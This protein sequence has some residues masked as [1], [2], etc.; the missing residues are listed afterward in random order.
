MGD[1]P[2]PPPERPATHDPDKPETDSTLD[3]LGR[4][5][6]GDGPALT[7]LLERFRPRLTRWSTGRIPERARGML[8][9][10]DLVQD[11]LVRTVRRLDLF[12]PRSR[13]EFHSYLRHALQNRIRDELRRVGARPGGV[14]LLGHEADAAPS[15][16]ELA[17]GR[18]QCARYEAALTR[19]KPED[20]E[21]IIAKMELQCSYTELAEVL[22]KPSADAARMTVSRALL[23]LAREIADEQP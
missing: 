7:T 9:T 5:H 8:E 21:A 15:P 3:L 16:L 17:I 10:A 12:E 13:G 22:G 4:A 1:M 18:D 6:R 23:R 2:P 20:R 19:L 14:P 11:V